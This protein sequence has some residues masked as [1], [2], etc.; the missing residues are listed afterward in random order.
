MKKLNK[1]GIFAILLV[2]IVSTSVF[3]ASKTIPTFTVNSSTNNK[4]IGN[5]T[6]SLVKSVEYMADISSVTLASGKSSASYT[7]YPAENTSGLGITFAKQTVSTSS[8]GICIYK[9]FTYSRYIST[10]LNFYVTGKSGTIK[11]SAVLS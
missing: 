4:N 11:N 10:K 9:T 6:Y 1:F 2:S 5:N 7:V 3:A 8:S